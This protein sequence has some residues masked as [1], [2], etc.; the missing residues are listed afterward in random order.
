MASSNTRAEKAISFACE[1]DI[2]FGILHLPPNAP[3][4]GVVIVVGGPQYR[5]GSHRIHVSLARYLSAKGFAVL[6]FDCRGMGDSAGDPPGFENIGPDIGAAVS[7]LR[8][9][10]PSLSSVALW[11]LCDAASAICMYVEKDPS[12]AGIAIINPWARTDRGQARTYLRH[13]YL[14]RICDR[15]YWR[16]ILRG[17]WKP[18]P[19]IRSLCQQV[20]LATRPT[21]KANSANTTDLPERMALGVCNFGGPILIVISGKDLTAREFEAAIRSSERWRFVLAKERIMRCELADSDHTFSQGKWFE[22]V[23]D[24]TASWLNQTCGPDRPQCSQS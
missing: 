17:T 21:A 6:R 7:K 20:G 9:E 3:N 15:S 18:W 12:I 10:I 1:G 4:T 16:E 8:N 14:Q 22:Q 24:W 19:A 2:L 23:A 11:G 13:Y 5:V